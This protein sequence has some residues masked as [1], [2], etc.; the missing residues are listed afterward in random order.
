MSY[1][2][3]FLRDH[4]SAARNA[5]V[6]DFAAIARNEPKDLSC[7]LAAKGAIAVSHG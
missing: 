5:L 6:A 4:L 1:R 3:V 2:G 7:V